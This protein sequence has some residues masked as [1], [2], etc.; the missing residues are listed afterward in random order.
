MAPEKFDRFESVE[1]KDS[2]TKKE[3]N[4]LQT[5]IEKKFLHNPLDQVLSPEEKKYFNKLQQSNASGDQK[6]DI[7]AKGL[8]E[9][10]I[11][12]SYE[13]ETKLTTLQEIIHSVKNKIMK[14]YGKESSIILEDSKVPN[15]TLDLQK[16]LAES[17]INS[18]NSDVVALLQTYLNSK[19][20]KAK[21]GYTTGIE[22]TNKDTPHYLLVDGIMG[23]HTLNALMQMLQINVVIPN[24]IS[25]KETVTKPSASKKI[26]TK[27]TPEIREASEVIS[28]NEKTPYTIEGEKMRIT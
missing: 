13:K 26:E 5:E 11:S 19:G 24:N 17:G 18:V 12:V 22:N 10:K 27:K 28:H 1:S 25:N 23:P 2:S 3:L 7:L 6:N 21:P 14:K 15:F 4:K 8:Y 9:T 20:I 16:Y